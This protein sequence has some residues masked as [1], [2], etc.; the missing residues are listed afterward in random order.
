MVSAAILSSARTCSRIAQPTILRVNRSRLTARW[1]QPSPV[2]IS[3]ISANQTPAF[4][5]AGLYEVGSVKPDLRSEESSLWCTRALHACIRQ[6][7]QGLDH[8]AV[9][10]IGGA[11]PGRRAHS[12][13]RRRS[14]A[15][16]G[17]RRLGSLWAAPRRIV[18][19]ALNLVR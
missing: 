9:M 8:N 17:H 14:H 19:G 11:A 7:R 4:A 15:A 12:L 18:D 16:S 1:S 10:R 2:G 3:V 13:G 6:V 5:G